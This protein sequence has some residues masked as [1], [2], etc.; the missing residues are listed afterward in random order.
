MPSRAVSYV[1]L[2]NGSVVSETKETA[3]RWSRQGGCRCRTA[4]SAAFSAYPLLVATI[5]VAMQATLTPR[6]DGGLAQQRARLTEH[7]LAYSC[8]RGYP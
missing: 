6:P 2:G 4:M 3:C 7:V 5:P 1:S 8:S